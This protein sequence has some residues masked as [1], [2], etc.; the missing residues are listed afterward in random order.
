MCQALVEAWELRVNRNDRVPAFKEIPYHPLWRKKRDDF[1]CLVWFL[2]DVGWAGNRH[3]GRQKNMY[4]LKTLDDMEHGT[5]VSQR[6]RWSQCEHSPVRKGT[7]PDWGPCRQVKD[8]HLSPKNK[9]KPFWI[10]DWWAD[11]RSWIYLSVWLL[12]RS[13]ILWC[14][15]RHLSAGRLPADLVFVLLF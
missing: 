13:F 5:H 7:G 4:M 11:C 14:L 2:S 12:I 8:I 10:G 9:R 6:G 15:V 1:I 3:S